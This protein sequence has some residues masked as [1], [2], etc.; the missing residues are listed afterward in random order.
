MS[1]A[2]ALLTDL[3]QLTMAQAYW[4]ERLA[5]P[6]VFTLFV[7]RLPVQR[8][9]LLACGV[10]S[11]I[12]YLENL[13]FSDD[14]LEYLASLPPFEEDWVESLRGFR[15]TGRVRAVP[16]GT[17]VFADEPILEVTAPLAEAQLVET[18]VLNE[19]HLQTVLASKAARVVAAA[20]GRT[21]VD[22]A[23]RRVHG[24]ETSLSAARAFFIAGV[25]ATSNVLAARLHGIPVSGTM[26]H[27]YV[28]AHDTELEAFRA[29]ASQY[30]EA[31]LLVDTYD[32]MTGVANVIALARELGTAFRIT[33]VRLDSGDLLALSSETRS[34]LDAAGLET[35]RIFASGGLQEERIRE[36]VAAG[37]PI[38]G[39]GVG[40]AMGVSADAP[41]LDMVYKLAEYAGE[42]RVK[43][44][45]GKPVLPGS[46][47]VFRIER[48]G[49]ATED[50]IGCADESIP[51]RAL[52]Q[53]A[54]DGGRAVPGFDRSLQ[55]A[56]RRAGEELRLLPEELRS[57]DPAPRPYPV[58]VSGPLGRLHQAAI[59]RTALP[60]TGSP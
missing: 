40:T 4:K 57:L 23:M 5:G 3:Y 32:T 14:E 42:E 10:A 56:R 28:Q 17:P 11:V 43:T 37:A 7:R 15:F 19:V 52:L 34:R 30:P 8:N 58:R 6:A 9:Y 54:M 44:S 53:L 39:F 35:V 48:D 41:S 24:P 1:M 46:K 20:G 60:A 18:L 50:V 31:V 36:L 13:S 12:E 45:P 47:Q 55:G 51:G 2:S 26:A 29:F 33:G 16:E 21:V 59:S 27:S 25:D 22:F 49:L 38:D